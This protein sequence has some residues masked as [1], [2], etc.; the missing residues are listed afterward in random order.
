MVK[1]RIN[2]KDLVV[3]TKVEEGV[4]AIMVYYENNR[5]KEEKLGTFS[6]RIAGDVVEYEKFEGEYFTTEKRD[7]INV[8]TWRG[9]LENMLE[10]NN[11][12]FVI[13]YYGEFEM[14]VVGT[15]DENDGVYRID[16]VQGH[17]V[18]DAI[19]YRETDLRI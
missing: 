7:L 17:K 15:A 1:V 19:L 12:A 14:V 13:E 8:E 10:K 6:I 11:K 2:E 9:I 5:E 16:M 4:E 18:A 3:E